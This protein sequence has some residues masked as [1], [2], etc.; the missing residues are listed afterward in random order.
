MLI[1]VIYFAAI[2]SA[3]MVL[4]ASMQVV[5]GRKKITDRLF[6]TWAVALFFVAGVLFVWDVSRD[7]ESNIPDGK[8][9]IKVEAYS[10]RW[11]FNRYLPAVLEVHTETD[12]EPYHDTERLKK[13]RRYTLCGVFYGNKKAADNWRQLDVDVYPPESISIEINDRPCTLTIEGVSASSL[14]VTPADNWRRQSVA[15]KIMYIAVPTLCALGIIQGIWI[16]KN[17]KRRLQE[18]AER[19]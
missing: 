2:A 6:D 19:S 15:N 3:A 17:G 4:Y 12:S 16:D 1:L 8:Y 14:G 5:K 18:W 10:S 9:N 11:E 7:L 13:V